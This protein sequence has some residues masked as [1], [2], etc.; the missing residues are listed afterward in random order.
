[1]V[2]AGLLPN[3]AADYISYFVD[4]G[5]WGSPVRANG[6]VYPASAGTYSID[7][8]PGFIEFIRWDLVNLFT[9]PPP[10]LPAGKLGYA[11]TMSADY[12]A[13]FNLHVASI[14]SGL[15]DVLC[16]RYWRPI[17]SGFSM[18]DPSGEIIEFFTWGPQTGGSGPPNPYE[19][20]NLNYGQECVGHAVTGVGY[21]INFDPDGPGPLPLTNWFI[22]HDNW[23]TTGMNIALPWANWAASIFADPR[24]AEEPPEI[25]YWKPDTTYA[26]TGM[27]DFSSQLPCHS[28][29]TAVTNCLWWYGAMDYYQ[30]VNPRQLKDE[31]LTYFDADTI[32]DPWGG[33]D[34]HVMEAGLDAFFTDVSPAWPFYETTYQMPDFRVMAE[35]LMKCQDVILLIGNWWQD[36]FGTWWRDG[37]RYVTMAGVDTATLSI[38]LSDPETDNAEAGS[39]GRVRPPHALHPATDGTHWIP[40]TPGGYDYPVSH[41]AYSVVLN[42]P[43]PG[44]T[45]YIPGFPRGFSPA[46]ANCPSEF[47]PMTQPNPNPQLYPYHAEVEYAVMICPKVNCDYYKLPYP[48]YA[49]NGMPDFDQKQNGWMTPGSG[50]WSWCGPVALANCIWWFDSKFETAPL[51]PRPF[52]PDPARPPINDHYPL[53]SP[54]GPWDDHDINNVVPFVSALGPACGVDGPAGAGTPFP[55]LQ[56]GFLSWLSS[57][58]MQ[59]RYTTHVVMGPGYPEI[60]DSIFSSQDVILLLGFYEF[61]P[62]GDCQRLGGHYVTCAG[63]CTQEPAICVSDPYFDGNEGEPPPGSAHGS[64]VHNDTWFVSGPHGT[65]DHDRYN[66]GPVGQPC[67]ISPATTVLT[68]YPN[69]WTQDGLVNFANQNALMPG[70]PPTQYQGGPIMVLVDAALIICPAPEQQ[71]PD[72]DVVPDS[73]YHLQYVNTNSTYPS[74]FSIFNMG[75]GALTYNVVNTLPWITFSGVTGNIPVGGVDQIDVTVNTIGIL[76]G[77]YVDVVSVASNDPDEPLVSK[78]KIVIEVRQQEIDICDFYKSPYLDYA[79]NGMPDFD[80]KQANWW[81]QQTGSFSWCGPVALANCIWWFDSKFEPSPI[82][83]RP[84]HP[85]PTSPPINDHYSLLGPMG[86]WDDH[87]TNNVAPFINA[88][89]PMCN[90]DGPSP[91]TILPMLQIGFHNWLAAV[92]MPNEYTSHLVFGPGYLEIRDSIISSQDVILLLGFYEQLPTQECQW[93]GGHYVTCAGVCTQEPSICISDPFFDTNE[94]EPPPGTAHGSSIHNDTWFVS[95][96]HGTINHDRYN[97]MPVT[98]PCPLSPA[99]WMLTDYPNQWLQDGIFTFAG[100][101]PIDNRV[102]GIYQG[103]PIMVLIEAALIICPAPQQQIPDINVLPDSI[104]HSI[105][106]GATI[107]YTADFSISNTGIAPLN[108]SAANSLSWLNLSANSGIVLHGNSVTIDITINATLISSGIY[109]DTIRVSSDDPD[110][111]LVLAPRYVIEVTSGEMGCDY[112]PGDINGNGSANGI[113]VTYGVSYL[114]GG[115][116][117]RDSCDCPPIAYPFYAAMDVNG[118]CSSNGIDI[119]FFVAY[120]KQMQPALLHCEDCPPAAFALPAKSSDSSAGRIRTREGGN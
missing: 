9:T 75:N 89:G 30:F 51:D 20:W 64:A 52:Y 14:D 74:D 92:G 25:T 22:C 80:Q 6:T 57:V 37:G 119:T 53:L 23:P 97:M 62:G 99:T 2:N 8:M 15:P 95:G 87:D 49:R 7:I 102:A 5:N 76:P 47:M 46:H 35:S 66:M 72:I 114:K 73:I 100:E 39:Y 54:M 38:A 58:G 107:T 33:T 42:S 65:I 71:I 85:N 27:P 104:Y 69:G 63:V 94:G 109:Y 11:W 70:A 101:N 31:L 19:T 84:F 115:N 43:S 18:P 16:F 61:M 44:G 116:A 59:G 108:W 93:L 17:A 77:I 48:D 3:T 21:F 111:P 13:G 28:G 113:D 86:P 81:N 79:Q 55:Q 110:E 41:D 67:P 106:S 68:D 56:G 45:W 90:V 29:A 10:A 40:M 78:P 98:M 88:L 50:F 34:V 26:Q 24:T 4:H 112:I 36:D 1:M 118:S 12:Q 83:P 96:P 120:L 105:D 82:D 117:P 60:R 32:F 103:N 91:G